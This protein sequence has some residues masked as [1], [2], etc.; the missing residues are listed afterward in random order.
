MV[1]SLLI[2]RRRAND[3]LLKYPYRKQTLR[4]VVSIDSWMGRLEPI[5]FTKSND[6]IICV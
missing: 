4:P 2:R 5:T 6:S 3:L 1:I